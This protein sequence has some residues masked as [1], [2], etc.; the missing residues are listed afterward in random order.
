MIFLH[1]KI[2]IFILSLI[3]IGTSLVITSVIISEDADMGERGFQTVTVAVGTLVAFLVTTRISLASEQANTICKEAQAA[4]TAF[5]RLPQDIRKQFK[6]TFEKSSADSIITGI[7]NDAKD[8]HKLMIKH[9]YSKSGATVHNHADGN[10]VQLSYDAARTAYHRGSQIVFDQMLY[11]LIWFYYG[12]LAPIAALNEF[13]SAA[14]YI[15]PIVAIINYYVI[16][17][18]IKMEKPNLEFLRKKVE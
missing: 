16:F 3:T 2:G 4:V 15:V 11:S 18:A 8:L 12:A 9:V 1:S 5:R 13:G 14:R 7:E 10:A 17:F 6:G